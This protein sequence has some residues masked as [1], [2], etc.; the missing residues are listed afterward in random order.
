LH[1]LVGLDYTAPGS[2]DRPEQLTVFNNEWGRPWIF[3]VD[4]ITRRGD[5]LIPEEGLII[6]NNPIPLDSPR[7]N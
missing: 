1:F 4:A 5:W 3:T 6:V 2:T 7:H